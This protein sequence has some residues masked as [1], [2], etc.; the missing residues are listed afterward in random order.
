[1][2]QYMNETAHMGDDADG[3]NLIDLLSTLA[4]S[5]RLLL[6][7]PLIV[8]LCALGVSYLIPPTYTAVT[9]F[10]PP[11]QQQSAAASML[12]SLGALGGLA[13]AASGLKNPGDQYVAFLKSR[14]LQG[15]LNER[16]KLQA[17]YEAEFNDDVFDKLSERV[18][19]GTG[20][21]GLISVEVDDKEPAF[22]AQLANA[23][24]EELGQLLERLAVTEAQQRRQFFEKQLLQT[25]TKL[26]QAEQTLKATGVTASVLKTNPAAAVASLAQLQAQIT[27]QEIKVA[28]MR[29]Y[30]TEYAPAFKQAQAELVALH[31]AESRAAASSQQ[32]E[33]GGADYIARYRDMK[34]HEA[35]FELFARQFE[36]AKVDESREGALIQV[37]DIATAPNRKSKPKK[38]MIALIGTLGAGF[39]ALIFVFVRETYRQKNIGLKV[40]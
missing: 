23:Y 30:L 1:M 2:G 22:A 18:R 21:D 19:I 11:Q 25:K 17:R 16:F 26:T 27:A 20:K 12:Q 3:I 7:V 36:L 9:K 5:W 32:V 14:R 4:K 38:M 34:Y 15:V 24:V 33:G 13:G 35:L 39:F 10:L 29:G 8:G 31:A 28:S 6:V 37:L 40:P